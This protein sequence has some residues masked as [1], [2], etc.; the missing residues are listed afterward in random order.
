MQKYL[1][2]WSEKSDALENRD[3]KPEDLV[4]KEEKSSPKEQTEKK[5]L[6]TQLVCTHEYFKIYNNL[7][8]LFKI[9][10]YKF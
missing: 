9:H 2:I 4:A 1:F 8:M 5:K 10:I 6:K 7:L 3:K